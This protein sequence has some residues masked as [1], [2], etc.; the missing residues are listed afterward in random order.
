MAMPSHTTLSFSS[1]GCT[2]VKVQNLSSS[3]PVPS[4]STVCLEKYAVS[5]RK[6]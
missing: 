2:V 1:T 4:A 6:Q 3:P 5:G